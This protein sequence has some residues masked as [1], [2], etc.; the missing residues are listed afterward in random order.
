MDFI[1]IGGIKIH[2]SVKTTLNFCSFCTLL[3]FNFA[4]G[5]ITECIRL[6]TFLIIKVSQ[7]P[8]KSK[9]VAAF[10]KSN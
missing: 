4:L 2:L 5:E 9:S 1:I 3:K 8:T 10:L 6:Q 7:Y